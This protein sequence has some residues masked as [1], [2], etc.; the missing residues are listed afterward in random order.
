MA[1]GV[2]RPN[3][4]LPL[5]VFSELND[6]PRWCYKADGGTRSAARETR[7]IPNRFLQSWALSLPVLGT[8]NYAAGWSTPRRYLRDFHQSNVIW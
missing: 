1:C 2:R 7:A 3:A 8:N 6:E 4:K 5:S